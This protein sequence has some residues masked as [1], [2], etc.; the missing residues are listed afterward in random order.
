LRRPV[1]ER[2]KLKRYTPP[3]FRSNFDLFIIDDDP[4]TVRKVVDLEDGKLWK[5]AMVE[6]MASLDK[7]EACNLVELL[8]RRNPMGRKWVFKKKLNVEGK[9]EKHKSWLVAKGYSQVEGIDFGE[10]FSHVSKLTSIRFVLSIVVSFDF[11]LEQM[12]A[13]TPFLHGDLEE[14]IYM[15]QLEVFAGKGKKE[16]VCKLKK[17]M[18]GLKKSP[19]MWYQNFDTCILGL[20][21]RISKA[22]HCMYFKLVGDCLIYLILYVDDMLFIGNNK[23]IIQDV[24]TQLSSKLDM[25]DLGVVN[26]NLGMKIK[27]NRKKMKL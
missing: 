1:R 4:R 15:K 22:Y 6:E 10:I 27:R 9:V 26:F 19:R 8:T 23:E 25:K 12:D 11:E 7:N 16:L 20:G 21:F 13:K 5:K 24:K 17:S 18:Y 2:R 14:E 3:D